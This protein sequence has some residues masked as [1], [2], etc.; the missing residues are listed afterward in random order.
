M[1]KNFSSLTI[2][3][4]IEEMILRKGLALVYKRGRPCQVRKES[5]IGFLLF[6][7]T[8]GDGY[9]KMEMDSELFLQRHYDHSSFAYHY[10]KMPASLIATLTSLLEKKIKGLVNEIYLHIFD[11]TALS[12]SVRE[13][14]IRQG[15]RNKTKLTLKYHTSLGY[16][17]PNQLVVV[18][19]SIA[20]D[21]HMSDSK[22]NILPDAYLLPPNSTALDLAFAVHTDIG[23]KFIG[24]IDAKTKKKLGKDSKLQDGDIIQILTK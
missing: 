14:R 20:S 12:T 5:L 19:G 9:E 6:A 11:S 3:K 13:E 1:L 10:S 24:A 21:K 18:E 7:K 4:N 23:E 17:P 22:G 2:A 15:T 16:D 8:C